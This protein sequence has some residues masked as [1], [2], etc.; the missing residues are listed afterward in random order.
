M[1]EFIIISDYSGFTIYSNELEIIFQKKIDEEKIYDD[2]YGYRC[3]V[4]DIE[5]VFHFRVWSMNEAIRLTN[6]ENRGY[7]NIS[8]IDKS[9]IDHF[10]MEKF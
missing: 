7:H 6:N 1:D 5:E 8:G 10:F 2:V 9:I 3:D 4:Y